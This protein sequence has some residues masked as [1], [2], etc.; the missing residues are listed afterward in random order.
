MT[1][2]SIVD[3]ILNIHILDFVAMSPTSYRRARE[4]KRSVSSSRAHRVYNHRTYL[5]A[6]MY[7][8]CLS[9]GCDPQYFHVERAYRR[10]R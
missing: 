7:Y 6:R 10:N 8:L 5:R 3:N 4:A 1:T 2:F 9:H